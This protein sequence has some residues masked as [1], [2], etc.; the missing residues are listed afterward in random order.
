ARNWAAKTVLALPEEPATSVA[1]PSGSPPQAIRSKPWI[2]VGSLMIDMEGSVGLR[3]A[4]VVGGC[5]GGGGP[6]VEGGQD[7]IRVGQVA[8]DPPLRLWLFLDDGGRGQDLVGLG[9]LGPLQ[10]VDHEQLVAAGQ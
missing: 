1:R 6:Q 2:S 4:V 5:G 10:H 8:D 9:Q 3:G 7:A